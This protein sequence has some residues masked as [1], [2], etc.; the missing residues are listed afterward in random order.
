MMPIYLDRHACQGVTASAIAD[1]HR[2]DLAVAQRYGVRFLT[3]WFDEARGTAFCLIDAPDAAT[4]REVHAASHGEVANDLIEVELSAIEA[5]LGRVSA[6]NPAAGDDA[7]AGAAVRTILFTDIV[8]S[9]GLAARLGDSRMVEMVRAHDALVRRA[10]GRRSGREVKHTGDGIMA[11]FEDVRAAVVCACEIQQ[12]FADFNAGR[13]E[14]LRI[15]IGLDAGE[16]VE[17][18]ADLFGV[19]VQRA[20]RLCRSAEPD[21]IVISEAVRD[22]AGIDAKALGARRLKGFAEAVPAYEVDWLRPS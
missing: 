8:D 12:A 4:A 7:P 16:P 22:G 13:G 3:Y 10:L 5:F 11:C 9:T 20:A 15:R 14:M 21:V 19:T 18:S 17:D 6:P 2:Q 1:M